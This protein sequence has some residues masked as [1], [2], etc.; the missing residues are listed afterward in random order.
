MNL[1]VM[2]LYHWSHH[3]A[4]VAALILRDFL[5]IKQLSSIPAQWKAGE[6]TQARPEYGIRKS[7]LA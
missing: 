2:R 4:A 7:D 1:I 3:I 5:D 6:H